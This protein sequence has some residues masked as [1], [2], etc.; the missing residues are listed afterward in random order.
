MFFFGMITI[1]YD[2]VI[3][4]VISSH[5]NRKNSLCPVTWVQNIFHFERMHKSLAGFFPL[6]F[7]KNAV[8]RV[9]LL[10][11]LMFHLIFLHCCIF[12]CWLELIGILGSFFDFILAFYT[13]SGLHKTLEDKRKNVK[14]NPTIFLPASTIAKLPNKWY[15][16]LSSNF[17]LLSIQQEYNINKLYYS[18]YTSQR[19]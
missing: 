5:S 9:T 8:M 6:N 17:F 19:I 1:L 18:Y 10:I 11:F 7:A 2:L 3:I 4:F 16:I 13:F 14:W 12:V 15:F